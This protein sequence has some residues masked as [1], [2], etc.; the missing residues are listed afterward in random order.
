[1]RALPLV[2]SIK[3]IR[4]LIVVV[5]PAPFAPMKP[6]ASPGS[7]VSETPPSATTAGDRHRFR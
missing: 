5:L 6:K 1:M 4:I 2:A 7:T 3:P